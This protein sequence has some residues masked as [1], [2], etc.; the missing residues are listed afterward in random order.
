MH[1]GADTS[2]TM[3][4][5][6]TLSQELEAA[7]TPYEIQVYSGAPHAFTVF[8]SQAYRETADTKSWQAFQDFLGSTLTGS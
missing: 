1:G 8:G 7:G 3:A 5:V 6:A 4:D 2:V